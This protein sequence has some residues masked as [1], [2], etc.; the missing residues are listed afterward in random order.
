MQPRM[1]ILL[2]IGYGEAVDVVIYLVS[3]DL[4]A[5]S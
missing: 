1:L 3:D 5:M 4:M 2:K